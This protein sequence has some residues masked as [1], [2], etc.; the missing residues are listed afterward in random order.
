MG[1]SISTRVTTERLVLRPPRT[2][3]VPELRAALRKNSE[4]LRPWSPAQH[5]DVSTSLTAV[6]QSVL[7]YR[8]EWKSGAAYVL[9]MTKRVPGEPIIG[10]ISL[11]G[12]MRGVF[13]NAYLGYWIDVDHQ[14][15]GLMTEAVGA[16]VRFAF[17]DDVQLH[18][19]Q[20]AIMPRN[21]ASVRVVEK[22]GF[23]REGFAE[24]YLCI[25]GKWEDHIIFARTVEEARG[26]ALEAGTHYI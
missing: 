3:D 13:Q 17:S 19:V 18:R 12:V 9:F 16:A 23:R 14:H 5:P 26:A 8:R 4:H 6:S 25:A 7:R 15:Q 20:A 10:R 2:S 1:P 11:G 21:P 24:R 22:V